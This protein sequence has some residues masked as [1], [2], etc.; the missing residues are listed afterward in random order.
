MRQILTQD[1]AVAAGVPMF[2]GYDGRGFDIGDRVEIHPGTDLWMMGA[3]FGDVIGA[4]L[5]PK[6]RVKVKL[7]KYS[8]VISGSEDMFRK[9]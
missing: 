5:T 3:R 1:E 2:K 4:S 6:D 9:V 7:D 8:N